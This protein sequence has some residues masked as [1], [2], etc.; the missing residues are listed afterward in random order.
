MSR[1]QHTLLKEIRSLINHLWGGVWRAFR[2]KHPD[3]PYLIAGITLA[4]IILIGGIV[5]AARTSTDSIPARFI[6]D[7]PVT[8]DYTVPIRDEPRRFKRGAHLPPRREKQVCGPLAREG[9]IPRAD[10]IRIDDKRVWWESDHDKNDTE[11]DHLIHR[12]MEDPLR[13]LIELVDRAGG[14][15]KVQDTYRE[16]GIHAKNSF[17]KVG[18]AIDLTCDELGLEKLA[19][20][21]WAAGFDWVY[22]EAPKRGGHHV[23]AS[24]KEKE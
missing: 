1:R 18:R 13:R 17:H 6:E 5:L 23:H 9:F 15:L 11:D 22:Y 16:K 10:L 4:G 14:T 20:L 24:V 2:K 21:T 8:P 3:R 19:K 12:S 7:H